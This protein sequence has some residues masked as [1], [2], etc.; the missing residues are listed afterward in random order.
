MYSI[1]GGAR[2]GPARFDGHAPCQRIGAASVQEGG[3]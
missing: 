2:A 3:G 1:S